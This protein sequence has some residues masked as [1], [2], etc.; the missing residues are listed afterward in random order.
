MKKYPFI[1]SALSI[2]PI[3]LNMSSE[4]YK[5]RFR[6]FVEDSG[7]EYLGGIREEMRRALKDSEWNWTLA[8][9]EVDFYGYHFELSESEL[10]EEIKWLMWDVF[11]QSL[12]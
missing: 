9:K 6:E 4:E 10:F 11:F 2:C 8:S 5:I 12:I 1:I 7:V 3:D